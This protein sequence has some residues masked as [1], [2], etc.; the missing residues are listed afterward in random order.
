MQ[1][2]TKQTK[3]IDITQTTTPMQAAQATSQSIQILDQTPKDVQV[4]IT[5]S[6]PFL[7]EVFYPQKTLRYPHLKSHLPP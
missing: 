7:N 3:P 1:T 2:D 4:A 6:Y 5:K